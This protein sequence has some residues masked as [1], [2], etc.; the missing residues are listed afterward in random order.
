M[1]HSI[2]AQLGW[3][4]PQG[5]SAPFVPPIPSL[6]GRL[7]AIPLPQCFNGAEGSE[8]GAVHRAAFL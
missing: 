3:K 8:V 7:R 5:L 1:D 6:Q 2:A 4:G